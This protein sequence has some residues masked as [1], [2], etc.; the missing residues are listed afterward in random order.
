MT[1]REALSPT[2]PPRASVSALTLSWVSPGTSFLSP[3]VSLQ[4]K[5]MCKLRRLRW[6]GWGRGSPPRGSCS[7]H[8]LPEHTHLCLTCGQFILDTSSVA[9]PHPVVSR[10]A[11]SPPRLASLWPGHKQGLW[12]TQRNPNLTPVWG[13]ECQCGGDFL[14]YRKVPCQCLLFN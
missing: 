6:V 10:P 5:S 12:V 9:L 11:N 7:Q 8:G 13:W 3:K 14:T 2:T 1:W 4:W